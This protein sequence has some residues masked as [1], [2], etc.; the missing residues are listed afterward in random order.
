MELKQLLP[1]RPTYNTAVLGYV[2]GASALTL[3]LVAALA[4]SGAAATVDYDS[5]P[6]TFEDENDSVTVEA[7]W[8]D[9]ASDTATADAAVHESAA[10]D[11]DGTDVTDHT[12]STTLNDTIAEFDTV[13]NTT[14]YDIELDQ[15]EAGV[16]TVDAADFADDNTVDL[17]AHTSSNIT[18]GDSIVSVT[19][20]AQTISSAT[21]DAD[22]G[23]STTAEFNTSGSLDANTEYVIVTTG[24]DANLEDVAF[25]TGGSGGIF[26]STDQ[27]NFAIAAVLL[28]A[29]AAVY[30]RD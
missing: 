18:S 16:V 1:N 26:A 28:I 12:A 8:F 23:N 29:G 27:R 30:R 10:Y 9:D 24:D 21:L 3:M 11:I 25:Q 20:T 4:V 14:T 19:A 7:I 15:S 2:L 17:S 22:P 13:T 5:D 6:F